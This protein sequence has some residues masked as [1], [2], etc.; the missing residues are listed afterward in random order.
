MGENMSGDGGRR[1][2][3]AAGRFPLHMLR[4]ATHYTDVCKY[5]AAAAA[6][7]CIVSIE[8]TP[9]TVF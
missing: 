2:G 1:R 8:Q 4:R 3:G 7:V 5:A 6:A 9:I